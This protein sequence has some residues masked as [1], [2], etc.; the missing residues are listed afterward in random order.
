MTEKGK[1]VNRGAGGFCALLSTRSM[2]TAWKPIYAAGRR[3]GA[4]CP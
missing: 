2:T 1:I 4:V 3:T